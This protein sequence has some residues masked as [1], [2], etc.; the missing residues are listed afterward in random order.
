MF[1]YVEFI[2]ELEFVDLLRP[3]LYFIIRYCITVRPFIVM[4]DGL[5]MCYFHYQLS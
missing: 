5:V 2:M 4:A 3:I 1:I